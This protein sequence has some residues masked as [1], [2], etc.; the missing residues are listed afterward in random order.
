MISLLPLQVITGLLI[1]WRKH[2]FC[3]HFKYIDYS[4]AE[5]K[6]IAIDMDGSHLLWMV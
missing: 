1:I 5:E 3:E 2:V 6:R 4:L